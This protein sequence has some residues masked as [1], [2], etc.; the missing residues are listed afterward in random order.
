MRALQPAGEVW[1]MV[2]LRQGCQRENSPRRRLQT[3]NSLVAIVKL[4]CHSQ[5]FILLASAKEICKA[6]SSLVRGLVENSLSRHWSRNPE[7]G[8]DMVATPPI[9][10]GL[11]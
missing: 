9:Y 2:E 1:S 8:P 5:I 10:F 6:L 11:C 3:L 7:L 4:L